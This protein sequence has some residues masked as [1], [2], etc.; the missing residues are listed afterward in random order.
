M[1]SWPSRVFLWTAPTDMRRGFPGL[2]SLVREQMGGDPRSGD[3]Y[4]FANRTADRVKALYYDRGY[5]IVY[6]Q[7][8]R[9]RF[10]LPRVAGATRV[11]M[12]AA[13][14]AL[15]LDGADLRRLPRAP[16]PP[17]PEKL[18]YDRKSMRFSVDA[19]AVL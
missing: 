8:D 12:T 5:V 14:L 13:E 19:A 3:L 17:R 11:E 7:L 2:A 4:V 1:L 16:A 18:R 10:L 6:K 9:G 15:L